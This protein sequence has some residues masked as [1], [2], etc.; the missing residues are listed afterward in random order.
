[1]VVGCADHIIEIINEVTTLFYLSNT[2]CKFG[3]GIQLLTIMLR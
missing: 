3:F 2:G 1:M